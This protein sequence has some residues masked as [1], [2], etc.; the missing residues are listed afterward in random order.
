MPKAK[1]D[2]TVEFDHHLPVTEQD[3]Q[4]KYAELR[5]TCPIGWSNQ[6]GGFWFLTRMRT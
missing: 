6:R 5:D 3:P 2:V 4:E 1:S